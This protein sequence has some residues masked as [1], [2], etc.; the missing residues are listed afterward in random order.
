MSTTSSS[1]PFRLNLEQQKKRAKQLLKA[2]L[3]E[4]AQAI[5]RFEKFHPKI[6]H[7][8]LSIIDFTPKLAD[9]QLVIARELNCKTWQ[10]LRHHITLMDA[11]REQIDESC[12]VIDEPENCLHI[13]C[14][15][16][17]QQTLVDAGFKGEFLEFSDPFCKGPVSY[18][19]NIEERAEFLHKSYGKSLSRDYQIVQSG[20]IEAYKKFKKSADDYQHVVLWFEHDTYD[21]FILIFL[22]SQYH[23]FGLPKHLWMITS[24]QFPG[25]VRFQ[26]LGQLPP[27]GLRVLWQTKQPLSASQCSIADRH[28]SAFSDP[29]PQ[30]FHDYVHQLTDD[31]L[32]YFKKAALRQ[33]KEQPISNEQLPLTQQLTIELL[34]ESSPQT[35]GQLFKRLMQEKEPLPFLGDIMYW[36]IL[37]N[38]EKQGLIS[39]LDQAD[40]WAHTK[41]SLIIK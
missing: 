27:E 31:S 32:P 9:A 1:S 7:N 5:A 12:S 19:Y 18:D 13:R 33:I 8:E 22:L 21:Q 3:L 15:S 29:N 39:F 2:F 40:Y 28:W 20:L 10:Q 38:M 4:D 17:I 35:A 11:L 36:E 34:M 6:V 23:R 24:N 30:V 41:I 16:D 37:L 26:G 25:N 14:G